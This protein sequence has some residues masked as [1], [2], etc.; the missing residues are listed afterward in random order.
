MV[1]QF[2]SLL[3]D[4]QCEYRLVQSLGGTLLPDDEVVTTC[5]QNQT[6]QRYG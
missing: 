5:Q 3:E 2:W 4:S 6:L 1:V